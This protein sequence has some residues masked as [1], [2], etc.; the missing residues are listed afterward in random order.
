MRA[1][2]TAAVRRRI[3]SIA[4]S[5]L[6]A[7]PITGL[8]PLSSELADELS[9]DAAVA[10]VSAVLAIVAALL[11]ASGVIALVMQ[12]VGERRRSLAVRTALGATRARLLRHV[13][14]DL[15]APIGTV[16]G[17][18]LYVAASRWLA[19]RIFGLSALDP[20]WIAVTVVVVAVLVLGAG[21]AGARP[22][23]RLDPW[24]ALRSD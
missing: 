21:C 20:G 3:R 8:R 10:R 4:A 6:P 19:A 11:A 14:G 1:E 16:A 7:V 2:D 13:L 18:G 9:D 24:R 5:T 22:I 23:W 15:A 12:I 17:V